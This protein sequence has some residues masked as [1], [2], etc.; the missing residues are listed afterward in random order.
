MAS[1]HKTSKGKVPG[2]AIQF[3]DRDGN[4]R[5]IRLG[6]IGLKPA[7]VFKGKVEALVACAITNTTPDPEVSTW[8]AG[9]PDAM[10][11][12]LARFALVVP[13]I[14]PPIA[15]TLKEW[16]DRYSS[17]RSREL[18][19]S[20]ILKMDRTSALLREFFGDDR[21][22]DGITASNAADWRAWLASR[23]WCRKTKKKKK[24]PERTLSDATVR[25]Y[26]R[27]AK[28]VFTAAVVQELIPKNP[29]SKLTS[30]TTAAI[31]TRYVTPA[32][33]DLIL[34]K[35]PNVA[36]KALFGLARFAGLR[37]PSE[38]CAVAWGD[39]D[40]ERCRLSVRSVKTERYAGH[41]R[42][43]L[44]ILPKLM[45]LLQDAFDKAPEGQVRIVPLSVRN[46]HRTFAGIVKRTELK[47]FPR[48][49]QVLR[50][51][52][53]TELSMTFPQKA[54]AVWLGH[55]ERVS[56]EHYLQVPDEL[57]DK[58]AGRLP[59]PPE[60][61]A[62]KSAAECA[63][64]GSSTEPQRVPTVD[65]YSGATAQENAIVQG[66]FRDF[67]A[68]NTIGPGGI[69]TPDQAIMSRLLYPLSYRPR[70]HA[71]CISTTAHRQRF[72]TA[73]GSVA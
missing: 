55:S 59:I 42:R 5:T 15:P 50:Q 51:S 3:S 58:A 40:W 31:R 43:T 73:D 62:A 11:A 20:S 29:F 45:Q 13:R 4:R 61:G 48:P 27:Y 32:E 46:L 70:H 65:E 2:R 25:M 69:R 24:S 34:A 28:I 60:K 36:W 67:E 26:V 21:P 9:L 23:T 57:Y 10:H 54:V 66:I 41:E 71:Y 44:P 64:E 68:E 53:A 14:P 37:V 52:C 18:R 1:L 7:L 30:R 38:A 49:F 56:S 39:V 8:L 47:P 72:D 22:I 63:A 33:A 12:K 35:C 19:R 6:K 16:L 17:Q